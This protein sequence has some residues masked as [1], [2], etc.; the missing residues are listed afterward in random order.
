MSLMSKSFHCYIS[1]FDF[2]SSCS[3]AQMPVLGY[4]FKYPPIQLCQ[5]LVKKNKKKGSAWLFLQS[6][7]YFLCLMFGKLRYLTYHLIFPNGYG[8]PR[9]NTT[10]H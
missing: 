3:P 4:A 8:K 9:I 5:V 7:C 6:L 10:Q 2:K 1:L